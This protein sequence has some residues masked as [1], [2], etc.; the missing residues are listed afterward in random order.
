ME[1]T[2]ARTKITPQAQDL[3]TV[4]M[5]EDTAPYDTFRASLKQQVSSEVMKNAA[6]Y[7]NPKEM[8]A[9]IKGIYNERLK[10][11]KKLFREISVNI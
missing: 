8:E 5:S 10:D 11:A 7:S 9:A 1:Q 6:N 4:L 3:F 2:P